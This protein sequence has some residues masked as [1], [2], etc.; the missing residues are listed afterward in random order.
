MAYDYDDDDDDDYDHDY[1]G[2]YEYDY[3]DDYNDDY[4]DVTPST[5]TW[6]YTLWSVPSS[7]GQSLFSY[8]ILRRNLCF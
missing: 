4:D 7:P 2:D 1:D 6:S 5:N 8:L 3:D